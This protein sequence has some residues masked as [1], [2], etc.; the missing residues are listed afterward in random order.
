MTSDKWQT[1]ELNTWHSTCLTSPFCVHSSS[2]FSSHWLDPTE[3]LESNERCKFLILRIHVYSKVRLWCLFVSGCV[4]S[5]TS[6]VEWQQF[7]T[8]SAQIRQTVLTGVFSFSLCELTNV[9]VCVH[10]QYAYFTIIHVCSSPPLQLSQGRGCSPQKPLW[11]QG[12]SSPTSPNWRSPTPWPQRTGS[13]TGKCSQKC[14]ELRIS[15]SRFHNERFM[16][17]TEQARWSTL[18]RSRLAPPTVLR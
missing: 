17:A 7:H 13:K 9:I 14:Q 3:S 4:C 11:I 8:L 16:S 15:R 10:Y 12:P 6:H 18:R 2:S 5:Q 1:C